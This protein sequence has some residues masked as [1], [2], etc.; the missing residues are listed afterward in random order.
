MLENAIGVPVIM[1]TSAVSAFVF[2][3]GRRVYLIHKA[4][5]IGREVTKHKNDLIL[6]CQ[7]RC[8]ECGSDVKRVLDKE[9][10]RGRM[11]TYIKCRQC[12]TVSNWD[13]SRPEYVRLH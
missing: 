13:I 2:Y 1:W 4:H 7:H 3:T 6:I 11:K 5:A 12:E 8:P 10:G 9:Y